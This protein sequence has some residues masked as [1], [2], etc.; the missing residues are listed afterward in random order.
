MKKRKIIFFAC[1]LV[2]ATAALTALLSSDKLLFD[3]PEKGVRYLLIR[4]GNGLSSQYGL[5]FFM[6]F[7][8]PHPLESVERV[9]VDCP[10]TRSATGH[11]GRARKISGESSS[12]IAT[13]VFWDKVKSPNYTLSFWVKVDEPRPDQEIWYSEAGAGSIGFKL[14]D[15]QMTFFVPS[16]SLVQ[17]VSDP[18]DSFKKFVNL[19]AV[20]DGATGQAKLYENGQPKAEAAVSVGTLPRRYLEFGR[21]QW[22]SFRG[23]VDEAAV[24]QRALTD[25]EVR[26]LARSQRPLLTRLEPVNVAV[27]K[28]VQAY[29]KIVPMVL[30]AFHKL[31]PAYNTYLPIKVG[32]PEVSFHFS[33]SDSRH[34]IHAHEESLLSGQ[35]T[36]RAAHFKRVIAQINGKLREMEVCLDDSYNTETPARRPAYIVQSLPEPSDESFEPLR[37]YPPESYSLFHPDSPYPTPLDTNGLVRLSID[38]NNKGIYCMEPVDRLGGAWLADDW[39]KMHNRRFPLRNSWGGKLG[40]EWRLSPEDRQANR[41]WIRHLLSC[42]FQNP[43]SP[44]EWSWQIRRQERLFKEAE[45]SEHTMSAFD[46]LGRNPSPFYILSDLDLTSAGFG[47]VWKSSNPKL[48]DDAGQVKRPDGDLPREVV[49]TATSP[50]GKTSDY[51]FRVVPANPRLP[52][53]MLHINSPLVKISRQDFSAIFYPAGSQSIPRRLT[54]FQNTGGGIKHH[55]NTSY[56]KAAK[57][58][59]SLRFDEPHHLFTQT[60]TKNLY[61]LSGYADDTRLRNKFSYD[62]FRSFS[63]PDKQ[64]YAPEMAWTEVFI[65]GNYYGVFETCTRIHGTLLG[66]TDKPDDPHNT[67]LLFKIRSVI[68]LFANTDVD[69]FEAILPGADDLCRRDAVLGLMQFTSGADSVTFKRDIAKHIDVDNLI[70]FTLLL[71][72][73]GNEDGRVTNFY[74]ARGAAEDSPFF[75]IPWDYDKTFRERFRFLGNHLIGRM[76]DEYPGFNDRLIRRWSELRSSVLSDQAVDH[77]ITAMENTLAGYM[78]WEYEIITMPVGTP[79]Y[80]TTVAEFR[81]IVKIRLKN[82]DAYFKEPTPVAPQTP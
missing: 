32:L 17:K 35:R 50:D 8:E 77:R 74:L 76:Q 9:P 81:R 43:W 7:D 33:N 1:L 51:R 54:G 72:F 62:T 34:F 73:A 70:D 61:L 3:Y 45:F 6:S 11:F 58:P 4:I 66:T 36:D 31:N 82:M 13:R 60:D 28:G 69:I 55:G 16:T 71:N 20:V 23:S 40:E 37:I 75:L 80:A 46:V 15:G 57:K 24:W 18:F 48:I 12:Y 47:Y 78:D 14:E 39:R 53:L 44:R 25:R 19:V 67:P 2:L 38:G 30:E 79:D 65:N 63:A 10:G 64:R 56:W 5:A 42:D 22:N 49:M 26:T 27:L 68:P 59:L 21:A 41:N 29:R 52:A